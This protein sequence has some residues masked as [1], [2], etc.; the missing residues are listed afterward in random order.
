[1]TS[2]LVRT[3]PKHSGTVTLALPLVIQLMAIYTAFIRFT[4]KPDTIQA[5][6]RRL[7]VCMRETHM[8]KNGFYGQTALR[9]ARSAVALISTF[10]AARM[11]KEGPLLQR[12]S[13]NTIPA[14]SVYLRCNYFGPLAY[15][16]VD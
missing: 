7:M 16:N 1:M 11:R 8:D 6:T 10:S 4:K 12:L 9:T 2:I 5:K 15:I 3:I 14:A 13:V